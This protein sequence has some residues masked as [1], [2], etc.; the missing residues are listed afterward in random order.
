MRNVKK[1]RKVF[2]ATMVLGLATC[3][4]PA[5]MI[6]DF[7]TG[8]GGFT[9]D[10]G[11]IA[12]SQST[13]T[14]ASGLASLQLTSTGIYGNAWA[15]L[16]SWFQFQWTDGDVLKLSVKAAS[17]NT[18]GT[19]LYFT[20]VDNSGNWANGNAQVAW[21]T[22]PT[23]TAWHTLYLDA[24]AF[25]TSGSS[26]GMMFFTNSIN[27]GTF[28]LDAIQI[29]PEPATLILLISGSLTACRRRMRI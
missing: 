23:D 15:S 8:V 26:W 2:L 22:L 5:S 9:S 13:D 14:A 20:Y 28:Y 10:N 25:N 3:L 24:S 29:V 19:P 12:L 18:G 16:T 4:A 17:A 11:S 6:Q 1:C 7:E 27:A 21:F